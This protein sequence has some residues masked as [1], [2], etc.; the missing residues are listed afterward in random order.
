MIYFIN[1]LFKIILWTKILT[2][3]LAQV[4][5]TLESGLDCLG[6][7]QL[8]DEIQILI[9]EILT[10]LFYRDATEFPTF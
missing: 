6:I 10:I 9:N 8:V 2:L 3:T 4:H 1:N 5:F 7:F